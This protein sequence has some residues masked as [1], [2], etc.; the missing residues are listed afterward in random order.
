MESSDKIEKIGSKYLIKE[1]IGSG[2][3]AKVF[4]VSEEETGKEYAA[5]VFKIG[6]KSYC[7]KEVNILNILKK[8]KNPYIMEIKE[9]GEGDIIRKNK[10]TINTKYYI[11]EYAFFGNIFDYI[12]YKGSGFGE[13]YSKVIFSKIVEGVKCIHDHNICNRD[14]K[15]E[16]ILLNADF[17][18]KI[19]DFGFA[20]INIPDFKDT[21]GTSIYKSPEVKA[22]KPYDGKKADIF[23]LGSILIILVAGIRGF[24]Q[25][26]PSDKFYNEIILKNINNYW[27][28]VEPNIEGIKELSS[29]FK[30]LYIQLITDEPDKRLTPDKILEHPWFNEIKEIKKIRKK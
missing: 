2:L 17:C 21:P 8:D 5:K 19:C 16:N 24:K 29:E 26:V 22:G 3:T 25:A 7:D 27:E 30:D 14:L 1:I 12:H 13:L 9:S 18:P 11:S 6:K 28:L 4:L 23:C 20:R 15:L 10:Q